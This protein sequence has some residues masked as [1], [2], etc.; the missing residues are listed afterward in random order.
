MQNK[1]IKLMEVEELVS[2]IDVEAN[3]K[4]NIDV[5]KLFAH[6]SKEIYWKCINNHTFKEEIDTMYRRKNKCFFCIGRSVWPGENDLQT[7]YPDLASEFDVEKNGI[8]P[9]HIS[10]KDTNSYWWKCAN[11]HPG[12]E[13]Q[14]NHRVERRTVCPYCT[15]RKIIKGVNDLQTLYPDIAKEWDLEGNDGVTPDEVSPF[16]YNSYK[17][18]CP[19]GHSYKK[20]VI[21]RTKFHKPIDCPKCVKARSTSFPEQAIYYY[22]KKCFPDALNRY[23]EP[24]TN[25]MELDIYI[26][27]VKIGIEYDGINFHKDEKQHDREYRKYLACRELGIKLVRIKESTETWNDTADMF[28]YVKKRMKDEELSKYIYSIFSTIF[29]F[30]MHLFKTVT[31]EEKYLNRYY[32][33]PTDFNV[34]GDRHEIMNYLVDIDKSFG[35]LYPEL[36]CNWSEEGNGNLTPFMFTPGSNYEATWKCSNCGNFWKSPISSIVQRQTKTCRACSMKANGK[37]LTRV[38]T[39]KHGSLAERS[40]VLLRQ[41]DFELNVDLS[42]Y[43]IPLNHN[44]AVNW[45]CDVCG[46]RWAS[47]PNTRVRNGKIQSCPHCSGRVAMPGVDDLAMLYPA[48]AKE[49][50][51]SKNEGVMPSQIRPYSN[52]RYYWICTKCNNSYAATAGSRVKGHG[53][54]E[55]AKI[56][57]G[58][59]NS[60][61]VGQYDAN[62]NLINTYYGLHEAARVMGLNPNSIFQAVKNGGRSKGFY[63]RYI[64]ENDHLKEDNTSSEV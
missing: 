2:L 57:I 5:S 10:P 39:L 56:E 23:R 24:F 35:V 48:V 12:F 32:G 37:T 22:V 30:Q 8:T 28:F 60:K 59:K 47:P 31:E 25:Q 64:L 62:G 46:H 17:W 42:P 18:K 50:D 44:F 16:T 27:S 11:N 3:E 41:W 1:K 61:T 43:E 6:S 29:L 15:E 34:A 7:L 58:K 33:F 4:E 21:Q 38:K 45:K 14:V 49:W 52:H 51:Y 20:K 26:P 63:W 54:P 55:C 40:D 19:K 53:C 13:Q 36:A 9:D